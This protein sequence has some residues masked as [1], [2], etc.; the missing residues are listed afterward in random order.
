MKFLIRFKAT[1]VILGFVA[2]AVGIF[3]VYRASKNISIDE[4]FTENIEYRFYAY[5]NQI[6]GK[7]RLQVAKLQET[8]IFE[9]TSK[10][11][12]FWVDLSDVVVKATVPVEY[13][14]FIDMNNGWKFKLLDNEIIVEVPGLTNSTPAVDISKLRFDV[15]KGSLLRNEKDS[16]EK[17]Q[18][19]LMGL[20]IEKSI[21]HRETVREQAR[22]SVEQFVKG[23]LTQVTGKL[24]VNTI[25]VHF[26]DEPE[27][28]LKSLSY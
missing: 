24:P 20:L 27:A 17:I 2:I 8:E 5:A 9:R 4:L 15:V 18:K 14:F 3:A 26:A 10:L 11:K 19:E 16:V 28:V 23:W 25:R 21:E 12:A 13:N 7:Q 22:T 1:L 6:T